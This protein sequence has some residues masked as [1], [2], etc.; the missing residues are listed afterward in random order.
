MRR[1]YRPMSQSARDARAERK[2]AEAEARGEPMRDDADCRRPCVLDLRGAGGPLLTL[3][4]IPRKHAWRARTDDG[5]VVARGAIKTLLHGQADA[6][7]RMLAP[8]SVD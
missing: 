5:A 1:H 7:A 8:M 3:E 4:P 6:L 2:R